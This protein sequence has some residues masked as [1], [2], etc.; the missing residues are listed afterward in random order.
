MVKWRMRA[1]R[2]RGPR[3]ESEQKPPGS[4][5]YFAGRANEPIFASV[6]ATAELIG[7][8]VEAGATDFTFY[9]RNPAEPLLEDFVAEHR[10]ATRDQLERAAAE[11]FPRFRD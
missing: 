4:C 3:R 8:Y 7:R 1:G 2:D 9:L 5:C 6:E 10:A 11:V